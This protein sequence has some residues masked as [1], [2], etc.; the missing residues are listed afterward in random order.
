[1]RSGITCV[2]H[3]RQWI[4]QWPISAPPRSLREFS[5]CLGKPH[6]NVGSDTTPLLQYSEFSLRLCRDVSFASWRAISGSERSTS[7][8]H[9]FV[10]NFHMATKNISV[11][12]DVYQRLTALKSSPVES[13]SQVLRRVLPARQYWTGADLL[14]AIEDGEWNGIGLDEDGLCQVDGAIRRVGS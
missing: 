13:Y 2:G 10:Y 8:D 3:G 9:G 4:S 14:R 1:M 5:L 6:H 11:Y 12:L 7:R